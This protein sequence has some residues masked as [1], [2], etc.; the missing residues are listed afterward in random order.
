MIEQFSAAQRLSFSASREDKTI[1]LARDYL[2]KGK[3]IEWVL[4][5]T[6]GK[7]VAMKR[8]VLSLAVI[9][10]AITE[11]QAEAIR[12]AQGISTKKGK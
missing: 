8:R 4:Q 5:Q 12:E 9:M 6:C 3:E 2:I 7:S 1:A 11:R 10:G